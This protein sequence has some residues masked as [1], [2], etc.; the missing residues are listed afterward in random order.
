MTGLEKII[1]QI[2]EE[3]R[4]VANDKIEAAK[5]AAADILASAKQECEQIKAAEEA[6][7]SS[8]EDGMAVKLASSMDLERRTAIL[9]AKQQLI[10]E[11]LDKA[12]KQV[13]STDTEA[14]FE[15]MEKML[16]KYMQPQEGEIYFSQADRDR[17]PE[18]FVKKIPDSLT[19]LSSKDNI[20]NGFVLVY[21]GIEENCTLRAVFDSKKEE[22]QDI[23]QKI[24]FAS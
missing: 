8:L 16:N 23:I 11:V 15:L 4:T 14:Y 20:E 24:L 1:S 13:C 7:L 21:G 17:M 22:L 2:E 6:K 19:L 10:S 5:K 18:S 3:G 12:Y 9:A